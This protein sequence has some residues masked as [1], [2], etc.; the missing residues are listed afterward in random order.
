MNYTWNPVYNL[1]MEIKKEYNKFYKDESFHFET[2]LTKLNNKKYLEVFDCLQVNQ[3]NEF[4]LIRYGLQ[5]MQRGMWEEED[6][7][8]RECRSVVIDLLNE[9]LVLTPFRKFFNLDE[10]EENKLEVV[11][12]KFNSSEIVEITNKLDGSMQNA[13]WYKDQVFMTGSMALSKEDSWRLEDG[14]SM[15]NDDYVQM[16]KDYDEYTFIFEYISLKDAHVVLYEKED[17]GL[18]LIGMRNTCTGEQVNY[19]EIIEIANTYNVSVVE[20]ENKTLEQLLDEMKSVSSHEKEGWV[21]N[22]DGHLIKL[23]CD[24]YVSI[25]RLLDKVSSVNVI[26]ENI[27]EDRFDDLLSKIPD[28]YKERV[29][30]IANLIF[31]YI[32]ETKENINS[33]FNNAP[34]ENRKEFMIW[35]DENVPKEL[36]AYV[37]NEYLEV[38]YNLLKNGNRG[39]KRMS[40]L[41]FNNN[42]S[43]LFAA[44]GGTHVA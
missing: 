36:K 4:L 6:S 7:I 33:F 2:W 15:I 37:R 41:G 27:A 22:I 28:K 10:V 31:T 43:V 19:N 3:H 14:Y 40:E 16:L 34:K 42:Y 17:E 35:V 38:K 44:V 25:H 8:Y 1:V 29:M 18:H 32:K 23:K 21:L 39:Y 5:E 26:I 20:M 11:Q 30:N 24:D 12:E 13:R 9:E